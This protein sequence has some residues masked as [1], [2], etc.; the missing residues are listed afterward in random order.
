MIGRREFI[1]LLGAA[2]AGWPLSGRAQQPSRPFRVGFLGPGSA[3]DLP[4]RMEAF[5]AGLRALGYQEGR[6]FVI[7][8]RWAD[9]HYDRLPA[10]VADLVVAM[11]M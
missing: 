8:F 6:D 10:L 4:Q 9:G 2:A 7:E 5:R 1:T 3:G 11:S